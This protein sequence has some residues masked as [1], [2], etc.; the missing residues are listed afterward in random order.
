M[1]RR[2][3]LKSVGVLIATGVLT[4]EQA[5]ALENSYREI[6]LSPSLVQEWAIALAESMGYGNTLTIE[7]CTSY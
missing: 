3:F 1:D 4:R 2:V 5:H 7:K 6:K